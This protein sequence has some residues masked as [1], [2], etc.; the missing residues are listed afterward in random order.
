M[1]NSFGDELL[2]AEGFRRVGTLECDIEASIWWHPQHR[3]EVSVVGVGRWVLLRATKHYRMVAMGSEGELYTRD[4]AAFED[5]LHALFEETHVA[6][7]AFRDVT[8]DLARRRIREKRYRCV[9]GDAEA[10]ADTLADR[11]GEL[12]DESAAAKEELSRDEDLLRLARGRSDLLRRHLNGRVADQRRRLQALRTQVKGVD[13]R[14]RAQQHL[15]SEYLRKATACAVLFSCC[16]N[17]QVA[18]DRDDFADA[19]RS[20]IKELRDAHHYQIKQKLG[21]KLQVY[22]EEIDGPGVALLTRWTGAALCPRQ[23]ARLGPEF[24]DLREAVERQLMVF[25]RKDILL[26][27]S[28]QDEKKLVASRIVRHFLSRLERVPA[29]S[30]KPAESPKSSLPVWIGRVSA[31]AAQDLRP[32]ALPLDRMGHV[33]VSGATGSGKSYLARVI[34]EGCTIYRQLAILI[35]DPRS[36]W[37]GLL[38]PENRPDILRRYTQFGLE[39]SQARAFPFTYHGVGQNVGEPLPDNLRRLAK[40]RRIISFKELDDRT[41]CSRFAD[42]LDAVFQTCSRSE[43]PGVR[44]LLVI[45][46]AQLFTKKR[47]AEEARDAAGRAEQSIDRVTREGRKYGIR[48]IILSQSAREFSHNAAIIRQN[49]ATRF[50]LQN[51]DREVEYATDFLGDGRK[52]VQLPPGEAFACNAAWG[53]ARIA[54][55]PPLSR[56]WEPSEAEIRALVASASQQEPLL[57]HEARALLDLA[58]DNHRET[59]AP[60]RVARITDRL[61]ITSRRKLQ[62]ITEELHRSGCA[63]FHRLNEQGRPLVIVP[64]TAP[65]ERTQSAHQGAQQP[66]SHAASDDPL[67]EATSFDGAAYEP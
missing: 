8:L 23:L 39:P 13:D 38:T 32:W 41:R 22:V 26:R 43:H 7:S 17:L 37:A 56:V 1:G 62:R 53:V 24:A 20:V 47:V 29:T 50:F 67:G 3:L 2:R 18:H 46:E 57:S 54:V 45:E 48:T 51:S 12:S 6:C 21:T 27:N 5:Y 34:V 15:E 25:P 55:R 52:L 35:A 42:V 10:D 64:A 40:G 28:L 11:F 9:A 33:Y 30:G 60:A 65:P 63:T 44:L 59:G 66:G 4:L 19:L 14:Q 61:G 58:R 49:V 36:Q 16:S 31:A